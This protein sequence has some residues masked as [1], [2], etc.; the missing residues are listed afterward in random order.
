MPTDTQSNLAAQYK[1]GMS[2]D[3]VNQLA[4]QYGITPDQV[5][6][7]YASSS[8]PYK[9]TNA[10][11]NYASQGVQSGP[12]FGT[13]SLLKTLGITGG[14][15]QQQQQQGPTNIGGVSSSSKILPPTWEQRH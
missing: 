1:A 8:N 6:A 14:G 11:P 2:Q 15:G 10:N 13:L 9:N 3:Y 4:K 7:I 5:Y 12:T